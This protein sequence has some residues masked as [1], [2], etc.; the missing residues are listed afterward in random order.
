M[1]R[2]GCDRGP[3]RVRALDAEEAEFE[4]PPTLD[5]VALLTHDLFSSTHNTTARSGGLR[6]R[7]T[8]SR[9]FSMNCGSLESFQVSW[10]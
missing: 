8:T 10:R 7:P 3:R 5:L 4:W 6:Y 2:A 1:S 9:T